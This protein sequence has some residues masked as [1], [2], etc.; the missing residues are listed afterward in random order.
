MKTSAI[1]ATALLGSAS[2]FCD[3]DKIH[4]QYFE[5]EGTN[6]DC[7]EGKEDQDATEMAAAAYTDVLKNLNWCYDID[8]NHLKAEC[9]DKGMHIFFYVSENC[10]EGESI[11]S[12]MFTY[13]WEQCQM[14]PA[15]GYTVKVT[16]NYNENGSKYGVAAISTAALALIGASY[17]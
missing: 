8:G 11:S 4:F 12:K 3:F 9:D 6:S 13:L 10:D 17:F 14:D 5:G 7:S 16:N 2:A 15:T 1:L